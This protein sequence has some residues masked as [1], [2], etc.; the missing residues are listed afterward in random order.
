MFCSRLAMV[1]SQCRVERRGLAR[2]GRAGHQNDAVGPIDEIVE[3]LEFLRRSNPSAAEVLDQARP[4]SKMRV[5]TAFSPKA[6]GK[7]DTTQLDLG[8]AAHLV[9]IAARPAGV[10]SRRCPGCDT[11]LMSADD[12]VV[13]HLGDRL[14]VVQHYRRCGTSPGRTHASA[15]CG[16]RSPGCRRRAA[17]WTR[18]RWR[19]ADRS[20]RSRSRTSSAPAA[21]RLPRSIPESSD[22]FSARLTEWRRP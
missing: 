18:Q 2:A 17:A 5:S 20:T 9:L 13:H 12:G 3:Q 7:V 4:G 1:L 21:S 14:N 8:V 6:T 11:V 22:R 10:A 16:C 19:H 15:R